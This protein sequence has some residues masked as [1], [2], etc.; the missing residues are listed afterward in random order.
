MTDTTAPFPKPGRNDGGEP[1][2]EC[3]LP[4]GE[5]CDICGAKHTAD[6]VSEL[7]RL[8]AWV[9]HRASDVEAVGELPTRQRQAENC[10]IAERMR[11]FVS[12]PSMVEACKR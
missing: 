10:R 5:M 7:L 4:Y 11:A 2:G 1:C 8:R 9:L 6:P 12:T 3:R